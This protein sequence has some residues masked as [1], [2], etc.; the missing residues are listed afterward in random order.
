MWNRKGEIRVA[1]K[2]DTESGWLRQSAPPSPDLEKS[3][4]RSCLR[5]G[6]ICTEE[7]REGHTHSVEDGCYDENGTLVCQ[8]EEG[9]GHQHIDEC[10]SWEQVLSCG[11]TETVGEPEPQCGKEEIILHEHSADCFDGNGTFICGKTQVLEHVHSDACFENVEDSVDVDTPICGMEE[12]THTE[13][14]NASVELTEEEQAQVDEV[15]DMIDALPTQ[16]EIEET[17]TAFEDAGDEDGYDAYLAGIVTQ[18]KAAYEA[19]SALMEAQQVKV[20]NSASLM[21]LEP[22]W[23][24]QTLPAQ[25]AGTVDPIRLFEYANNNAGEVSITVSGANGNLDPVNG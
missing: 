17:L 23:S 20:T 15:I 7:E 13:A 22:L 2:Y 11:L 4:G 16:E 5:G 24:V 14:C 1:E 21:A 25:A 9:P 19:Y 12:H 18:A 8:I 6:L 3:R 10:Y